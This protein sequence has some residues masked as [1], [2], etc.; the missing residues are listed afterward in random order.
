[1]IDVPLAKIF[2]PKISSKNL[3]F[4]SFVPTT[5]KMLPPGFELLILKSFLPPI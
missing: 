1:M 3:R 4:S 5:L 2:N